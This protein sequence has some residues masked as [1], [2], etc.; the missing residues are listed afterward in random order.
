[1]L[2]QSKITFCVYLFLLP[3]FSFGQYFPSRNYTTTEGLP[4]NAV[5]A[6]FLDSKNVLWI[7]T[8][9]GVSRME[10]GMFTNLDESNGLGHNSCW[11]ITEDTDG[12]IWFASYSGG[13]TKFDGTKFTVLNKKQ[14]LPSERVRKLFSFKNKIYAGTELGP[15]IIDIKTNKVEVPTG[16]LPQFGVFLVSDFFVF[17]DQIYFSTIN[18][19]LFTIIYKDNLPV[20]QTVF[21]HKF[22]YGLGVYDHIM[23]SGNKGF[24]DRFEIDDFISDK[25]KLKPFGNSIVWDFTEDNQKRLYAAAWGVFDLSGGLYTISEDKMTDISESYGI[26]SK[27]LLNVVYNAKKN[28]LYV[29]SK[30]NGIYEV[31][32]DQIIN[33][34]T[35]NDQSIIDFE[36]VKRE[37]IVLHQNGITFLNDKNTP[38]KSISLSDFKKYENDF[39][40]KTKLKLPTHADGY[41]ELDYNIPENKID[42]YEILKHQNSLWVTSNIGIFELNFEGKIVGYNPIHTYKIGFTNDNKF[43]ETIP[44]GGVRIYDD[45]P[46]LK[47]KHFSEFDKHTPLDIVKI[48][49]TKQKTYLISVFNGLF[50]HEK[51]Q[52]KSYLTDGIWNEKKF[53]NIT[54]NNKG[55]LILAAE[56]GDV[57]VID[58][59]KAFKILK[60]ISKKEIIGNTILFLEAY[61]DYILIGTEKGI[62]IY[63]NGIIRLIDKEQGLKDSKI[64]TSQI[65]GNNL[66]LGTQKGFYTI[67][68][69]RLTATQLTVSEIGISQ[70]AINNI[71]LKSSEYKWFRYNSKQLVT[72]YKHNSFSIDFIPKGHPFP[73][74]LKFR[75][76]LNNEN[77]WSPYSEK[78]NLFLPYLPAGNYNIMIEV[79]DMN[80]GKSKVFNILQLYIQPPFWLSWW[81]ITL[82]TIG[83]LVII[84]LIFLRMKRK[85][86]EKIMI[87]RR[88]A[89]TKLEAL[90]SQMNPHFTFNAMNTIQ[91]YISTNETKDAMNYISGFAKLIRK[92]LENS[93]K[94]KITI[95]EE[96]EYLEAYIKI[97]NKRLQNPIHYEI[98]ISDEI[99]AFLTEIPTMLLQPFVENIFVHAFTEFS[100]NPK[101]VITFKMISDTILE[102]KIIDNGMGAKTAKRNKLHQSKGIQLT[103]ERLS[104]LDSKNNSVEIDFTENN[105]TTV[106]ILLAV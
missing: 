105:G 62:N 93:S 56:F 55:Q 39:I 38:S 40:K 74:K 41:Y 101:F 68:L 12:N 46:H 27:N 18:E 104:L 45:L 58:D 66:W 21:R 80:A 31:Q 7:G 82:V 6:L 29:G 61:K 87:Q 26:T 76:R 83:L 24:I 84:I 86:N 51:G 63:K 28:I 20:I 81:F 92:T 91:S 99:E 78:T 43:I 8:E 13:I 30:D 5:R 71:P 3:I 22:L 67:D 19:G 89:E 10:N 32:L 35:F 97:E 72:D 64:T 33:Y 65:F 57:F 48:V 50:V 59:S 85:S 4:N 44:Y 96:I 9:N 2:S 17:N 88:I 102:C 42:F 53:K 1:M 34:Y 47:A 75:Y 100:I 79:F 106:T 98:V 54:K 60:K 52:F 103:K 11:D 25:K 49:N 94:Q 36:S 77:R 15:A 73:N 69:N 90:L 14:K 16:I 23:Y 37:K 70:I 95:E